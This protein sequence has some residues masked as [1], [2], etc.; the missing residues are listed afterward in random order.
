MLSWHLLPTLQP[1]LNFVRGISLLTVAMATESSPITVPCEK[2][3]LPDEENAPDFDKDTL[4]GE[5]C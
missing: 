1:C 2:E 5:L 4:R 3:D